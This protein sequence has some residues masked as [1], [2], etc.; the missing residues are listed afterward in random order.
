VLDQNTFV[1]DPNIQRF[2]DG[3]ESKTVI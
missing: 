1:Y 3:S 2:I